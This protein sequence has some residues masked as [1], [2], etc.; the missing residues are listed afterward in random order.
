MGKY[1]LDFAIEFVGP[2]SARRKLWLAPLFLF[3]ALLGGRL[4]FAKGSVV[5]PFIYTRRKPCLDRNG[6]VTASIN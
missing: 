5:A 6:P 1:M 4:V 3:M 2:M